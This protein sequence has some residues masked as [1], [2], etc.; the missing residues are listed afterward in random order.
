MSASTAGRVAVVANRRKSTRGGLPA[1]RTA[2]ERAGVDKPIWIE[3]KRGREIPKAIERALKAG[4]ETILVWGGDGTVQRAVH[5]S[6]GHDVRLAVIPAGSANVLA[7]NLGIPL[8]IA[9]AVDAAVH[10]RDRMIDTG[11]VNGERFAVMTGAG[12]DASM[13][14]ATESKGRLGPLAYAT[15]VRQGLSSDPFAARVEID[16]AP[17]FEGQATCVLIG[18]VGRLIGGVRPFRRGRDDDG[19]LDVGVIDNAGAL[20]WL[21]TAAAGVFRRS[22]SSSPH[23]QA[24]KAREIHATFDRKVPFEIDGGVRGTTR[25]LKV[26]VDPSSLRV[27]VP[28]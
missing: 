1:L 4:A 17:W 20:G 26:R 22:A 10:G 7:R 3:A 14:E 8:D 19:I 9:G 28:G 21:R 15:G 13:L 2:L 16:G 5:A 11:T 6:A 25:E 27:R 23:V 18:N 24:T 12:A